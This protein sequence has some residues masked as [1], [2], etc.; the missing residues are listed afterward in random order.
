MFMYVYVCACVCV[1]ARVCV[2]G[3]GVYECVRELAELVLINFGQAT[4]FKNKL[5]YKL[6][7]K[8]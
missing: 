2:G 4:D 3:V 6:G 8:Q 1:R 7:R 5:R